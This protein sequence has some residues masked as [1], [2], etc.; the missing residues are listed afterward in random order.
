MPI[1][2][3]KTIKDAV[4]TSDAQKRELLQKMTDTFIEVVGEV[5]RPFTYCIIEETPMYE[6]SLAG[7]P[8]P[9]FEYLSGPEFMGL[10]EKSNEIM[11]AYMAQMAAQQAA[12]PAVD[13]E[14]VAQANR[15]WSGAD[16]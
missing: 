3:V 2:T 12:Q 13:P 9:D 10:H 14:R 15:Q 11:R 8:L 4:L 16:D 5:A 1:I 6:W 7:K